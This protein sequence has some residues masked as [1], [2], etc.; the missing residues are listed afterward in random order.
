M[1]YISQQLRRNEAG[2]QSRGL[3]SGASENKRLSE[4]AGGGGGEGRARL[5]LLSCSNPGERGQTL[6]PSINESLDMA[7]S[8][9]GGKTVPFSPIEGLN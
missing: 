8:G 7:L 9:E 4:A 6:F 5:A 1:S 2:R 3:N